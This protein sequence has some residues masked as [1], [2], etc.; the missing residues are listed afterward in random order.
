ML[1]P[2]RARKMNKETLYRLV[3]TGDLSYLDVHFA[4]LIENLNGQKDPDLLLAAALVSACSRKGHVCLDLQGM[5]GKLLT[6]A[7]HGEYDLICPDLETWIKQLKG[8]SMVG[9][10]GDYRPLI[11][12]NQWRLYLLRYWQYQ[13]KLAASL[14]RRTRDHSERMDRDGL[15]EALNGLFPETTMAE[16]DWQKIAAF[17]AARKKFAVISGGP[18]TGKT[19]TVAR[20]LALLQGHAGAQRLR[21]ALAAP[22]GKAAARLQEAIKTVEAKLDCD[23]SVRDAIPEQASTIHRLLGAI[24]D[25]PYFRHDEKNPLPVD[26]VVVDEASMVDLALMSKLVQALPTQSKLILLGDKDQL[27]SVEAGAVLGDIC[28]TGNLHSYSNQFAEEVLRFTDCRLSSHSVEPEEGGIQDCI[29]QLQKSYRFAQE[30]GIG[31]L[32][33]AVNGG[34][35]DGGLQILKSGT[36]SGLEWKRL[37]PARGLPSLISSSVV[38]GFRSYLAC[39]DPGVAFTLFDRFRILCALRNGPFGVNALNGV[40]EKILA[41]SGLIHPSRKWYAG[42]P[43]MI[44]INDYNLTLFNGDVG[45]T[46]PDPAAG[47]DLRVFF[48]GSDATVRKFHPL[49]LPDHETVFAMTVHKS[50]GSEFDEV[51]LILPDQDSPVLTRELVY[52]AITR[53]KQR[54]QVWGTE[55]I[56]HTAV[57]RRIRR[58]SG[59]RDLL[60]QPSFD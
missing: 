16:P 54:V 11:L 55:S 15:R 8:S 9:R 30:C 4:A 60:W 29:V 53:A 23:P 27:A 32:S 47:N 21:I 35:G 37:P 33:Q 52:T 3:E 34:D 18:G 42:R 39:S 17:C 41:E 58:M 6:E 50:Q 59:L 1:K 38:Q 20:I 2:H 48:P 10:P 40:V 43:V 36:H 44:R 26:A 12:D 14:S 13:D 49:R 5:A 31:T 28:D 57:S 56:F 51:L 24:P 46:M 7:E 22:T 19:T 25:S 45:I